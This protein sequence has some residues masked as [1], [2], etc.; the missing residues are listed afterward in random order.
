M[1]KMLKSNPSGELLN[2]I[3][4]IT[5]KNAEAR[6]DLNELRNSLRSE[7]EQLE[8]E[9][10][11]LNLVLL[12]GIVALLGILYALIRHSRMNRRNKP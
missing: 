8:T 7:L 10:K 6:R 11:V 2:R 9:I 3:K 4:T 5:A 1:N 12:P